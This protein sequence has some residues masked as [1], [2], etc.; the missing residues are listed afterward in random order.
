MP[1]VTFQET[2]V[3]V[4][5]HCY[6]C[7]IAWAVTQ[8]FQNRRLKDHDL[9][10]CPSGHGQYYCGKSEEEKLRDQLKASQAK[11]ATAQFELQV[12]EKQ[13]KRL[14]KRIANGVCPCCHRQ[15]IQMTRHMRTKHPEYVAES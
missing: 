14:N 1:V 13:I 12:N 10:Y 9:F 7:G 6:K 4:V 3:F 15:F 2:E 5:E 8:D 11:L